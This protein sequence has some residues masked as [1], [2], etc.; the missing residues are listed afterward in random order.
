MPVIVICNLI[1][2]ASSSDVSCFCCD[3]L[4]CL[5]VKINKTSLYLFLSEKNA[6]LVFTIVFQTFLDSIEFI[7]ILMS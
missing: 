1:K 6:F 7:G 4:Y 3:E 2:Y 5:Y